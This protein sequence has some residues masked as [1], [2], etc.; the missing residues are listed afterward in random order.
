VSGED[1]VSVK[2]RSTTSYCNHAEAR[3]IVELVKKLLAFRAHRNEK[4]K[5]KFA[6]ILPRHIGIISGYKGQARLIKSLLLE[7]GVDLD[8]VKV[9]FTEGGDVGTTWAFQG[10]EVD[11]AIITLC[12]RIRGNATEKLGFIATA[13]AL[14]VQNSRARCFQVTVGNF[15]GWCEAIIDEKWPKKDHY[16][17]FHSLVKDFH[18]KGDIIDG[19]DVKE[20]LLSDTRSMAPSSN[21]FYEA[22]PTLD[23][24]Q[25]TRD[26]NGALQKSRKFYDKD[27][28]KGINKLQAH[29]NA[30][31]QKA[32]K[33]N[34]ST[35]MLKP[36]LPTAP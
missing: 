7:A 14:C 20:V 8:S 30:R 11:I 33:T 18:K 32:L 34:L 4:D 10:S 5:E 29:D 23:S 25:Y 12:C 36:A 22:I 6:D 21:S 13:N 35:H 24:K 17:A 9:F 31:L 28:R 2:Y 19:E 1:A 3:I 26:N 15:R 27:A 16:K